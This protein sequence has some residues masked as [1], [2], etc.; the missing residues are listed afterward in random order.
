MSGFNSVAFFTTKLKADFESLR[1]GRSEEK[2]LHND[3]CLAFDALKSNPAN[4]T[5]I[6][7]R[8][9]PKFYKKHYRIT[10]LWKRNLPSG[11]RL[12]YTIKA[13]DEKII[14]MVLEWMTHKEYNRRF[15]YHD[16]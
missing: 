3:L 7:K 14:C 15:G 16:G 12:T 5:R 4:G 1:E 10:N 8:I 9:W 13:E 11:W 6:P 2:T